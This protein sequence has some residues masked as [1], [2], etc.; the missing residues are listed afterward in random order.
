MT[1]R[2][3]L[4]VCALLL[5]ACAD[6]PLVI[7]NDAETPPWVDN[8]GDGIPDAD[9]INGSYGYLSDPAD[10]DTDDDGLS[11]GDEY[12]ITNTDPNLVDHDFD[13]LTDYEEYA[14][15]GTSPRES[16]SDQDG[17][18]DF[19][20][21]F[22]LG[23]D[24]TS[25]DSDGDGVRDGD[26]LNVYDSDPLDK[27]TDGDGLYDGQEVGHGTDPRSL[28][29]DG[30]GITDYDEVAET[31]TDPTEPDSDFDGLDDGV[32][33]FETGTSPTDFDTDLDGLSDGAEVALG[34][35]Y[36]RF[37][38]DRD[39]LSDGTE[40]NDAGSDPLNPDTDNDGLGDALEYALGTDPNSIDTDGDLLSDRAE[41]QESLTDPLSPDTDED[42][43]DDGV[44][45][46]V[47][48]TDPLEAD[49]DGDLLLD[50]DEVNT[51]N[52]DPLDA[53]TDDD[54][55]LD[56]IEIYT[57]ESNPLNPDTDGDDLLDGVEVNLYLTQP[58]VADTDGDGL[59]D[60]VEVRETF[61][62]PLDADMDSDG[63]VDG[64][65][66]LIY[67]TDPF[68]PDTDGDGLTD[69]DEA[70]IWQTD[71]LS[72]DTDGG[73]R[74]DA[75][76]VGRG[77]DPLD[78]SD[79]ASCT[80]VDDDVLDTPL[81]TTPEQDPAPVYA[82]L[83]WS[84]IQVGSH[85]ED[86][87]L[88]SAVFEIELLDASRV[89]TCTITYDLS[90]GQ[91]PHIHDTWATEGG[92]TFFQPV[93]LALSRSTTDCLAYQGVDLREL[94]A[95]IPWGLAV[96]PL[97]TLAQELEADVTADGGNW[98]ADWAPYVLGAFVHVD[99]GEL[100]EVGHAFVYEATCDTVELAQGS[101]IALDAPLDAQPDH[102]VEATGTRMFTVPELIGIAE[103]QD[104]DPYFQPVCLTTQLETPTR[105]EGSC[106]D[107]FTVDLTGVLV[108]STVTVQT[109]TGGGDEDL[110]PSD[111]SN[112]ER[113]VVFQVL[114]PPN[115]GLE[116]SV[117]HPGAGP[118]PHLVLLEEGVCDA[119]AGACSTADTSDS[120]DL[121]RVDRE[122]LV[123]YVAT[124]SVSE[125]VSTGQDLTLSLR[126]F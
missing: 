9:E 90:G 37:D 42:G 50:G 1:T 96:G 10:A 80:Y 83:H 63:L 27:D 122:E 64:D 81:V 126:A 35:D 8:D 65:E 32:E 43:L 99:G 115:R 7:Q 114:L 118:A 103:L 109:G 29:T 38:S 47:T 22:T 59:D 16:D 34:T 92:G 85:F 19:E 102:Y 73:G 26:E 113:D 52:T 17:L 60:G 55:L 39:G 11:D 5:G 89:P 14:L 28:D 68:H 44:E 40:V 66:W 123:G 77:D 6:E 106:D 84:G 13:G 74:V 108:G 20:E 2:R 93:E 110:A 36:F 117:V 69:G 49:T 82:R 23:T 70:L 111:C 30:D 21:L 18:N 54:P 116:A 31:G 121:L 25:A 58:A 88:G 15:Y 120:C 97:D 45:L 4:F 78:A 112:N 94:L 91:A 71:G 124:I 3:T 107:P 125:A 46:T 67:A 95:P 57:F 56:G 76:E 100:L 119:F 72:P 105:G 48:F 75:A 53:D 104:V 101:P 51:H 87:S 33:I 79:D 41:V 24:P 12:L 98:M 86:S 61:T 62:D